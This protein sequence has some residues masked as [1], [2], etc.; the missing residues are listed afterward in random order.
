MA[1]TGLTDEIHNQTG[2]VETWEI[3][4]REAPSL[5]ARSWGHIRLFNNADP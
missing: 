3:R 1:M 4:D 5:N 2:V